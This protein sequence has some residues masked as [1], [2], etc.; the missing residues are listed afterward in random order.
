MISK[1]AK[2][3][4]KVLIERLDDILEW[5]NGVCDR[6]QKKLN[7]DRYGFLAESIEDLIR[8]LRHFLSLGLKVAEQAHRRVLQGEQVPNEERIFSVFEPHTDL[9]KRG[10]AG[11]PMEF[12]HM[13]SI[14]Q[15]EQKFITDYEAFKKKPV[16][17]ELVDVMLER[18]RELF[19]EYPNEF[20]ADKGFYESMEK[21][22]ELEEKID[23][24]AICKKGSRTE[25]E[26]ERE[27]SSAFRSAQR[28]R[29]GVEGSISFLKRL[30]GM[31]RCMNKG[32][33]HY[34]ATVGATTFTHNLLI[35]AR[36]Y[37]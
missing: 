32:W 7:K 9:I 23:T 26:A 5:A 29:A 24:V 35:L 13:V 33:E 17:Y 22:E 2:T 3:A 20:S 34:V 30:L 11:K 21:I 14:Q 8:V 27:S 31:W 18:H 1:A 16:D 25:E 36:G 15:V 6:L 12:G 4:Y 28:F 19:G 10:K 37:G